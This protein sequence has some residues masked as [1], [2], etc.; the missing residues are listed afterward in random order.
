[1]GS[2]SKLSNITTLYPVGWNNIRITETTKNKRNQLKNIMDDFTGFTWRGVDAFSTFGAFII[3][4]KNSLKFYNG[5]T[6]SNEYT[7]PMFES[8][9]GQ[10]TG[11][12]FQTQ[13]IDFTIGVYWISEEDYRQ[14]IYWLHPYE[15]NTLTFDF[16]SNY[17][18]QVKLASIENGI[19]Y[20][21]GHEIIDNKK[22]YRYYTEMKLSFEVQG[23]PCVYNKQ[24]YEIGLI[25]T[26]PKDLTSIKQTYSVNEYT[27]WNSM[28]E[29]PFQA[30]FQI[31]LSNLN[32]I[33]DNPYITLKIRNIAR[34]SSE[35]QLF[36]VALNKIAFG[37]S[38]QGEP[39]NTNTIT[40]KYDSETGLLFLS[41]DN[42]E[43][44]ILNRLT[45]TTTGARLINGITS[46]KYNI[47]GTYDDCSYFM[48]DVRW[49]CETNLVNVITVSFDLRARDNL[50]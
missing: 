1:M 42:N 5:P 48:S 14:M 18:Y 37:T 20:I 23:T 16:E 45:T 30:F 36:S 35:M 47:P 46:I 3:N 8:A 4:N 2:Y 31:D 29:T 33:V 41:D 32:T 43:Y 13:K 25:N 7:K 38:G 34:E 6:Y 44:R 17:Y 12:N 15:I 21:I 50:I 11:V 10:L 40:I 26:E 49:Y 27:N 19:R 24:R 28:L 22:S 39:T 9:A